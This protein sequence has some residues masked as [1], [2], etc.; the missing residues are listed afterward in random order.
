MIGQLKLAAFLVAVTVSLSGAALAQVDDDDYYY[1][2]GDDDQA[3]QYGY[4]NG[5]RDGYNKGRHEG[6]ENDPNDYQTPDWRQASRGY[7]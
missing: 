3:R 5:Y 4:Q 1:H 6:R 2:R 7:Q